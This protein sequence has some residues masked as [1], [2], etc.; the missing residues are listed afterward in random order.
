[1]MF[2]SLS[3]FELESAVASALD[4]SGWTVHLEHDAFG[5]MADIW[6]SK[7]N[8]ETL[9]V[10]CKTYRKLV[11]LRTVRQFVSTVRFLRKKNQNL[12]AWLVTTSGFTTNAQAALA[13]T[14][15]RAYTLDEVL[16][17]FQLTRAVIDVECEKWNDEVN[18]ARSNK[19]RAFVITP[20][21]AGMDDVF[22]LGVLWVTERLKIVA[23]RSDTLDHNGE[24]IEGIRTAIRDYDIII[25]DT[26]GA[27]PNVCY[28]V[29]FAHALE[30]YCVLICRKGNK[31]P[32]D[33]HGASHLIYKNIRDLRMSLQ[34]ELEKTL[35]RIQE[36]I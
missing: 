28:E 34:T 22:F 35:T 25:A 3:G 15:I 24:I 31:I 20:L 36:K 21:D 17:K 18:K 33:L 8:S 7:E 6:A 23:K 10:E 11:G 29:G 9:V 5:I 27:N 30:K 32:F 14:K 12:N 26:S 1:M 16:D 19:I 4:R 13:E 2:K